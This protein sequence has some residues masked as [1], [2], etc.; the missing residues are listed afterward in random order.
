MENETILEISHITKQYRLGVLGATT[1]TAVVQSKLAKWQGKED[2]NLKIGQKHIEKGILTALND[3]NFKVKR[4]ERIGLIGKNGAGKST[5]LKLICRIT[6]PTSGYIGHNGRVTSMLEIGM[7]FNGELTG[8]ENIYLNGTILGMSKEEI[9]R[10]YQNIVEFSEVGDF[11]ETPVK[12]YSSGMYLRLA[13]AVAVFLASD[14]VIMDEVLAVGDIHFQNKCIQKMKEIA[15]SENRTIIYVSHNMDTIRAL[16]D[17]VIVLDEGKVSF[18][19]DVEEGI[20]L[21]SNNFKAA[22][23]LDNINWFRRND[24]L[25]I[26]RI[27][28]ASYPEGSSQVIEGDILKVNLDVSFLKD[29]EEYGARIEIKN[30]TGKIIGSKNFYPYPKVKKGETKQLELEVDISQLHSGNYNTI[31]VIYNVAE[32][33]SIIT[34]DLTKGLDFIVNKPEYDEPIRWFTEYWGDIHFK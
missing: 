18:D 34:L 24:D 22:T 26:S 29:C 28:K 2:P 14:I 27:T 7:G 4:G 23:S 31:Y 15:E 8:K 20:N 13:F 3:I 6:A 21:Y 25:K 12:R 5:L 16:C 1:L 30:S 32:N 33:K 9:D 17:R 19:G 10:Q 11:I